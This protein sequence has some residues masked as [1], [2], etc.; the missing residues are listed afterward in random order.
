[1]A[2]AEEMDE[3]AARD[4][5]GA[6]PRDLGHGGALALESLQQRFGG[7]EVPRRLGAHVVVERGGSRT[8]VGHRVSMLGTGLIGLFYTRTLHGQRNRD[9]VHVVYS[10]SEERA[11]AFCADNDVPLWTTDLEEASRTWRRTRS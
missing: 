1:M 5:V 9:R 4:R 6:E 2:G 11:K 10:R 7:R 8:V 3:A